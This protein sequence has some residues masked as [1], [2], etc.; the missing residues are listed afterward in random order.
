MTQRKAPVTLKTL[1]ADDIYNLAEQFTR[2][3]PRH[4]TRGRNPL[5]TF[6]VPRGYNL[7]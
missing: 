1:S 6:Q 4:K 2:Q 7:P 3:H 5:L